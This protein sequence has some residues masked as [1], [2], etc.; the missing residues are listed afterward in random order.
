MLSNGYLAYGALVIVGLLVW[1]VARDDDDI[2]MQWEWALMCVVCAFLSFDLVSARVSSAVP[3]PTGPESAA[4]GSSSPGA[5]HV[6]Q[7]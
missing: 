7:R 3:V 4:Q 6:A 5:V 1:T 2:S